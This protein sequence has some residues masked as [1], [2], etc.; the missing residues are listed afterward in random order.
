MTTSLTGDLLSHLHSV[1]AQKHST[2]PPDV[3][4]SYLVCI[5]LL[6]FNYWYHPVRT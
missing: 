3:P 6:V 5:G 4:L 2:I 1:A